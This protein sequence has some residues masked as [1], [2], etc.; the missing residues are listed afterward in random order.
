MLCEGCGKK[1]ATVY[2]TE[3]VQGQKSQYHLCESCAQEK[4]EAAYQAMAGVFS[5]NQ[6]LSGLLNLDPMIKQRAGV[7][8]P[9]CDHCGLSFNQF[10]QVGRF[11]CPH[12]YEAFAS[13][14]SSLLRKIQSS[15]QHVGKIPRRRGG[16]IAARRELN[17]LR[18]QMQLRITEERFE[19]AAELRDRIR[20]LEQESSSG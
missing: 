18:E 1:P 15:D 8:A 19:E 5:V 7:A 2:F 16:V 3:I 13:G 10:A 17:H 11:G 4:G 12:C 20:K 6:L 9:R 14:L